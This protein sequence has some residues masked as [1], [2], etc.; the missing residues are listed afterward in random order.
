MCSLEE[1]GRKLPHQAFLGEVVPIFGAVGSRLW[2][3]RQNPA[4]RFCWGE[5]E[6]RNERIFALLGGNEGYG[7]CDDEKQEK[8][9][10][11]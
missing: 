1:Q 7:A 6:Q 2:G 5:E 9:E 4:Q 3:P 11:A 10:G 8:G